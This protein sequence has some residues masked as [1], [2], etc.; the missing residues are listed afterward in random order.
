MSLFQFS[1]V[2]KPDRCKVCIR[3]YDEE[4]VQLTNQ[5]Y[6][7]LFKMMNAEYDKATAMKKDFLIML[8]EDHY[9]FMSYLIKQIIYRSLSDFWIMPHANNVIVLCNQR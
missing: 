5:L 1:N 4:L 6:V 3:H 8:G 2:L 7:E 9:S